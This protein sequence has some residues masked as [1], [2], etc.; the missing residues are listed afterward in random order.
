V[1]CLRVLEQGERH[2][3]FNN[4]AGKTGA[5]YNKHPNLSNSLYVLFFGNHG[6]NKKHIT[7]Q[8]VN[9]EMCK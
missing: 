5:K 1:R 2:Y 9:R 3:I 8:T 7:D 4:P 6:D